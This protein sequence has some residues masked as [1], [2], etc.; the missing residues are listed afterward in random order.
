MHTYYY[1]DADLD[2]NAAT[3]LSGGL[4]KNCHIV[5]EAGLY[6]FYA[7]GG[8][9]G[10]D[11]G[12]SAILWESFGTSS[13]INR[14]DLIK[15]VRLQGDWVVFQTADTFKEGNASIHRRSCLHDDGQK[16]RSNLRIRGRRCGYLRTPL[17]V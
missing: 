11:R 7:P 2:L 13:P 5:S 1:A 15:A 6:K 17:S 8:K 9:I 16:P 12:A 4:F 14:R 3:T 10:N